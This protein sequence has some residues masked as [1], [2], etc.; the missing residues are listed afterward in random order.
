[1]FI[2]GGPV[3]WP[4]L[5]MS[6]VTLTLVIERALY[7]ARAEGRASRR[8]LGQL[9]RALGTFEHAPSSPPGLAPPYTGLVDSLSEAA[10]RQAAP[11]EVEALAAQ[12][13]EEA[14]PRIE[15]FSATLSTI[16]TAAPM[17]GILGTVTG[18][19]ASFKVLSD[20]T[21]RDPTAVAGGIAEALITTAFGL[22]VALVTLFPYMAFRAKVERCYSRMETLVDLALVAAGHRAV[23]GTPPPA[24]GSGVR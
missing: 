19:I 12:A 6:L 7:W 22:I 9:A 5:A 14:R 13:I 2:A 18:I 20:T 1:M 15:R 3:M 4:L 11:R 10:K 8:A 16:I 17:L 24:P 23:A 21:L